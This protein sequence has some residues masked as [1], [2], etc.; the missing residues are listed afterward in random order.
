V[1]LSVSVVVYHPDR[2]WLSTTLSTLAES[3][4]QAHAAGLLDWA[5][6]A[7]VDNGALL[8]GSAWAAMLDAHF[9]PHAAWLDTR[10]LAGHGNIGYGAAN[11]LAF[12]QTPQADYLLVLNPDVRLDHAAISGGIAH[13]TRDT[14]CGVVTPVAEA[15]DGTP[16]FLVKSYPHV[17]VLAARGFAPGWLR[18]LL[19]RRL[20]LYERADQPHDSP[21]TD[22]RLASGCFLLIRGAVFRRVGGF[23][24][25]FF[26]YFEDF[27]LSFR[28]G[29]TAAIARVP[30]C[31]IVH[32]GGGAGGKG[33][34][35]TRMFV[36]SAWRF[37]DKHGWRW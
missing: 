29:K 2:D 21:L 1:S 7:L 8:S 30:A 34:A 20:A 15:P 32:A 5:T 3:L 27:D 6:V 16:L 11:N 25:A 19:R 4:V 28:I 9:A 31:R 37:F 24:P 22:V 12:A 10:V 36:R 23:D 33:F 18:K 35:H 17:S 14:G 26:L 13:L